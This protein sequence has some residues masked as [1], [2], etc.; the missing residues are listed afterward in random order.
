MWRFG[1]TDRTFPAR[2]LPYTRPVPSYRMELE[3][4]RLRPG[5]A[6]EQVMDAALSSCAPHHVDATDVTLIG[7]TPR[8]RVRFSV[9]GSSP[10]EENAAAR[11][12]ASRMRDAVHRIADTGVQDLRRRRRGDWL[13]VTQ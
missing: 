4:G 1:G 6:P 11:A 8:I 13:P 7:G 2:P 12:T 3:I 9:P 5:S 10:S